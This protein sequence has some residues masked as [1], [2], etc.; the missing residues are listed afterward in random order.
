M[1]FF[2]LVD[3]SNAIL[4]EDECF[5]KLSS[6]AK[7]IVELRSKIDIFDDIEAFI[8]FEDAEK[9]EDLEKKY[10]LLKTA[11]YGNGETEYSQRLAEL[12]KRNKECFCNNENFFTE[13]RSAYHL[14]ELDLDFE[15]YL[16]SINKCTNEL[17]QVADR[18]AKNKW[19]L[20]EMDAAIE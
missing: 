10:E 9:E 6:E 20:K 15:I 14:T 11:F 1:P 18:L 5:Q 3:F 2:L 19:E 4:E 17:S 7:L 8:A 12:I 13:K 16:W